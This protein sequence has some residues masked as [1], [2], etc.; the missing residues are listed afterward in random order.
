[1]AEGAPNSSWHPAKMPNSPSKNQEQKTAPPKIDAALLSDAHDVAATATKPE[2]THSQDLGDDWMAGDEDDGDAWLMSEEP[3]MHSI[4]VDATE[5][6]AAQPVSGP[7]PIALA[8]A[9]NE[10][11]ESQTPVDE[12]SE[13]K[14]IATGP[15]DTKDDEEAD[16]WF[17]E[18]Q[19]QE[20]L[21]PEAAPAP[22]TETLA[23]VEAE[24][25]E[26]MEPKV[27][28][29]P[30]AVI[31]AA[32]E[33]ED[34]QTEPPSQ[35]EDKPKAAEEKE[36]QDAETQPPHQP[37]SQHSSSMSFARTVSHEISFNDD[38]ESEWT[39]S[40]SNTDQFK[41]MSPSD[42]TNSFPPVPPAQPIEYAFP[43]HPLPSSQALDVVEEVEKHS[44]ADDD[45]EGQKNFWEDDGAQNNDEAIFQTIGGEIGDAATEA[46]QS[47]F[48]E[49][50]PLI[51]AAAEP[52][53][54][55][56]EQPKSNA[57]DTF[58][59]DDAGDDFFSQPKQDETE[60]DF[61]QPVQRK[62]T[63]QVIGNTLNS[64]AT[65][66]QPD[67][68]ILEEHAEEDQ[69]AQALEDAFGAAA[70]DESQSAVAEPPADISAKWQE[71]FGAGD[72]D[73]DFLLDDAANG[74]ESVDAAGFLGS[75]D[76]GLLLDDD[77][78]PAAATSKAPAPNPYLP[79]Q[80]QTQPQPASAPPTS[81]G[82]HAQP[83]QQAPYGGSFGYSAAPPRSDTPK[84]ESFAD[85][86]KGGYT[87]PYDL[88]TDLPR[89]Q[90]PHR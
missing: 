63:M 48:E 16:A 56:A 52:A 68:D 17:T 29:Q 38:D 30:A 28:L 35:V 23:S 46:S 1:M 34:A 9:I 57:F 45:A 7:A 6:A 24:I 54:E 74:D 75:D 20:T 44:F 79:T 41:F 76:E 72:D 90:P 83:S 59:E 78:V 66:Q 77:D 51:P 13:N 43:S 21:Q 85:K 36:S 25:S 50:L 49:G 4:N 47:R 69:H 73:D 12:T 5:P 19:A 2:A 18:G 22:S 27:E 26:S 39:L 62:S 84:A 33:P 64:D 11:R 42:R 80:I 60:D 32:P 31:T 8:E 81:H 89:S 71:A 88:P 67:F 61:M 3:T 15:F 82:Y 37:L 65:L 87:S 10:A 86:A 53:R 14:S 70:K 40:R 55:D 58:G